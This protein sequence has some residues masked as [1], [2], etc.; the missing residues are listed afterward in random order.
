ML[1]FREEALL[2]EEVDGR[3]VLGRVLE[4]DDLDVVV[5]RCTREH[6][7]LRL[8]GEH[9]DVSGVQTEPRHSSSSGVSEVGMLPR[10]KKEPLPKPF[11]D[12]RTLGLRK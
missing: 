11:L 7:P 5:F 12:R 6:Q 1:T 3:S 8:G 2:I 4:I 9:E 10:L